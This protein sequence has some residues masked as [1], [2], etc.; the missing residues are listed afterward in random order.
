MIIY[1]RLGQDLVTTIFLRVVE[2]I[3]LMIAIVTLVETE[4]QLPTVICEDRQCKVTDSTET[5]HLSVTK[6]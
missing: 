2:R 1:S 6:G 5:S 4:V 3:E